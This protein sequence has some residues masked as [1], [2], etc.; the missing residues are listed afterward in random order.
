MALS[1]KTF[2]RFMFFKLPA[3]WWCGVRLRSLNGDQAVC[4]VTHRW[5]NQNPFRSMFWAVQGMAAEFATGALVMYHI[6]DSG[7]PVSMLVLNNKANFSK[8]ATGR[9]RF[10]CTDGRE[11]REAVE[12][13]V[14]SGKGQTVWMRSVGTNTEGVV[15]STFDFEWT[16]KVKGA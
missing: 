15:V 14:A 11:V 2:N 7:Q 10:T 5:I 16:L 12:R 13:A 6:R 9:I 3:A 1:A 8:K 4:T